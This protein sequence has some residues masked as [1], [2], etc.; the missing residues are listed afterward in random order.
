MSLLESYLS[1]FH[2]LTLYSLRE[3]RY[4]HNTLNYMIDALLWT[5]TQLE[6]LYFGL[7]FE[8][9]RKV[10]PNNNISIGVYSLGSGA[11]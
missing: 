6:N 3:D 11:K 8:I 10:N 7:L 2:S 4:A 5:S 1:T 9:P